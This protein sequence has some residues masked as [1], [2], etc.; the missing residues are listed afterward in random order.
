MS[1]SSILGTSTNRKAHR[2]FRIIDARYW[3]Q[4][5]AFFK[6][7]DVRKTADEHYQTYC[8]SLEK[9]AQSEQE[10]KTHRDKARAVLNGLS[11]DDFVT[12][13]TRLNS[14][15]EK[16]L[17]LDAATGFFYSGVM[18]TRSD[19]SPVQVSEQ[20]ISTQKLKE[21]EDRKRA[22]RAVPDDI[23]SSVNNSNSSSSKSN[24]SKSNANSIVSSSSASVRITSS[25]KY[26]EALSLFS[27]SPLFPFFEYVFQEA[28]D[29]I[30][31][32]VP[33]IPCNIASRNLQNL[34]QYAHGILSRPEIPEAVMKDAYVALSCIV[35]AAVPN[36]REIFG[37]DVVRRIEDQVVLASFLTPVLQ[38][39]LMPLQKTF[40]E[41][42]L[43]VE[44]LQQEVEFR[45][46]DIARCERERDGGWTSKEER[47]RLEISR[48]VYH[49]LHYFCLMITNEQFEDKKSETACVGFW[50]HVWAVLFA[51][52]VL[53]FDNGELASKATK[54]DMQINE[55][56]FGNVSQTGGRKVDTLVRLKEVSGGVTSYVECSVNE[57]KPCRATQSAL[58]HQSKKVL[59]INRS[60]LARTGSNQ[61]LAFLDVCGFRATIHGIRAIDDFY[62]TSGTLGTMCLPTNAH[63]MHAFL[64][65]ESLSL[66]FRYKAYMVD[67]AKHLLRQ[68][69]N[70]RMRTPTNSP[71]LRPQ[72]PSLFTPS[73]KRTMLA[74]E[75]TPPSPSLRSRM[76]AQ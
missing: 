10:E 75:D 9:I 43:D 71:A 56:L 39:I 45:L 31:G 22:S 49:V 62:G 34:I 50:S 8:S 69:A 6:Y 32:T 76:K 4:V 24:S 35:S 17:A 15:T 33:Q 70:T 21:K 2:F 19:G 47:S 63:E 25:R 7:R 74:R 30:P 46:A 20:K 65:G 67:F 28:H 58:N 23:R 13:F 64:T 73:K 44:F 26:E 53:V 14:R 3:G 66:L 57:H 61:T 11:Y 16:E 37:Q 72:T 59:R 18:R 52:T 27:D 40:D 36:A 68:R 29:S 1:S 55:V 54:G 51:K 41:H 5:E 60:I 38:E 48:Q 12:T 42:D